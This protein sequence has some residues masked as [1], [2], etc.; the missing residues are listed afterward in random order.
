MNNK[1]LSKNLTAIP[2]FSALAIAIT[3]ANLE[4]A[5]WAVPTNASYKGVAYSTSLGLDEEYNNIQ[6]TICAAM[7]EYTFDNAGDLSSSVVTED[8]GIATYISGTSFSEDYG[9]AINCQ[10]RVTNEFGYDG[11]SFRFDPYLDP[12]KSNPQTYSSLAVAGQGLLEGI[13]S[14]NAFSAEGS[15]QAIVISPDGGL[16]IENSQKVA[17]ESFSGETSVAVKYDSNLTAANL[18][19]LSFSGARLRAE[20]VQTAQQS[21]PIDKATIVN[22]YTLSFQANGL[23]SITYASRGSISTF[24]ANDF[25]GDMSNGNDRLIPLQDSTVVIHR[26]GG[27]GFLLENSCAYTV[28]EGLI[29][30]RVQYDDNDFGLVHDLNYLQGQYLLDQSGEYLTMAQAGNTTTGT[31]PDPG[32]TSAS[33]VTYRGMGLWFKDDNGWSADQQDRNAAISG[34]YLFQTIYRELEEAESLDEIGLGAL[35]LNIS[36]MLIAIGIPVNLMSSSLQVSLVR[37]VRLIMYLLM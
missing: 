19:G 24:T 22:D 16:L 17:P 7:Y 30:V 28:D 18:E 1:S 6:D 13:R 9:K 36:R 4:A 2:L 15:R 35:T 33:E 31:P 32:I 14:P 10:R 27:G 5:P 29:D 23:C 12:S 37:L 26:D 21:S 11:V 34:T 20:Y 8:Y 3:S 25:D